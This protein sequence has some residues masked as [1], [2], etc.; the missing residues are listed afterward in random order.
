MSGSFGCPDDFVIGDALEASPAYPA[1]QLQE[2]VLFYARSVHRL[3]YTNSRF[4]K[5]SSAEGKVAPVL[6]SD[7]VL[8]ENSLRGRLHNDNRLRKI[9]VAGCTFGVT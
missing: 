4:L 8:S 6:T 9:W 5:M 2:W 1:D 3:R 7:P